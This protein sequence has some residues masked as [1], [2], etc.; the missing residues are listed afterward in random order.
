ML[1]VS[2]NMPQLVL[3]VDNDL[4]DFLILCEHSLRLL[5][6]MAFMLEA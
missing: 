1:Q 3:V 6:F 2:L 4:G 5:E